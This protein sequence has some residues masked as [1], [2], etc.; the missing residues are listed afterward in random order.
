MILLGHFRSHFRLSV[1]MWLHRTWTYRAKFLALQ[2]SPASSHPQQACACVVLHAS[3]AQEYHPEAPVL[4]PEVQEE[5][6]VDPQ[7]GV[8]FP[9]FHPPRETQLLSHRV[10]ETLTVSMRLT[11]SVGSVSV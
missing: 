2:T 7:A 5:M 11:V 9:H 1:G 4:T 8:D 6:L 3:E 10:T